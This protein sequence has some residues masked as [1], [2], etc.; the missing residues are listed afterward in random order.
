MCWRRRVH[1]VDGV[2]LTAPEV[3]R[4]AERPVTTGE[5]LLVAPTL[6]ASPPPNMEESDGLKTRNHQTARKRAGRRPPP[7][8]RSCPTVQGQREAAPRGAPSAEASPNLRRRPA[9]GPMSAATDRLSR[10]AVASGRP[11]SLSAPSQRSSSASRNYE[12]SRA[13][14]KGARLS[15][16]HEVRT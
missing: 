13:G 8:G 10:R 2:R 9:G 14:R 3:P 15:E 5:C 4:S 7:R 11:G 1:T 12:S 16:I 6:R